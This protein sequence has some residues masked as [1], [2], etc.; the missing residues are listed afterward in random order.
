MT[1]SVQLANE[2]FCRKNIY[3]QQKHARKLLPHIIRKQF[4]LRIKIHC[5]P[6]YAYN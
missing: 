3:I 5:N 4:D 2:I 1:N 6:E